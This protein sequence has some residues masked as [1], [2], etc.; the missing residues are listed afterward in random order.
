[1]N[2]IISRGRQLLFQARE[3]RVKPGRDEKI[4]TAWN[5][6]ML[7]SFAEAAGALD[8]EDYRRAAV[9]NAEFLMSYLWQGGR[10]L[11]SFKDGRAKFN[12]YLED[13]A[14]L[15]D[16]LLSLYE[17][18]FDERWISEAVNLAEIMV[19]KFGDRNH[20]GF[21]FTSDDH[22]TLIHRKKE[23][24]DHAIPSGNSV[25]ASLMLRLWKH[26]GDSRWADLALGIMEGQA[27]S[28]AHFPSAYAHMLGAAD[29]YLGRTLEIAIA[30]D[31]QAEDTRRMLQVIFRRY[32]PNKVIAC[33]VGE[34]PPLLKSRV[35]INGRATA[36]VCENFKCTLPITSP[37]ELSTDLEKREYP[38]AYPA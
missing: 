37:E 14:F 29:F 36:Y 16:G 26:T 10:L 13:Y 28:M 2:E 4:L 9:H 17:A 31:P 38:A 5:G 24:M 6:L 15:A 30:G 11:R 18:V 33:G 7:R 34:S 32:L 20:G 1:L 23:F 22:E 3:K 27:E 25:A 8:R 12:A 19:H 35:R 21:F